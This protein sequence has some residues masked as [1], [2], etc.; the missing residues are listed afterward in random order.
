ML[1]S[2]IN[3]Y[4]NLLDLNEEALRIF[5]DFSS[6]S[7]S[8]IYSVSNGKPEYS[9]I[10]N[11]GAGFF[12]SIS[13]SGLFNRDS[14]TY[15]EVQNSNSGL[16]SDNWTMVFSQKTNK[17][18]GEN[19]GSVLFSSLEGDAIKSGFLIGINDAN[20]IYFESFSNL[21]PQIRTSRN[22]IG[23]KNL[24]SVNLSP[25]T[26]SFNYFNFNNKLVESESY[27]VNSNFILES[28]NWFLGRALNYYGNEPSGFNGY[29]DGF[30]YFN[31]S[32]SKSNLQRLFSGFYSHPFEIPAVTGAGPTGLVTG[33]ENVLTGILSVTGFELIPE[34]FI[35]SG[36]PVEVFVNNALTGEITQTGAIIEFL[37]NLPQYCENKP[38]QE[39]FKWRFIDNSYIGITGYQSVFSGVIFPNVTSGFNYSSGALSG[40]VSGYITI[41]VINTGITT[42]ELTGA[43]SGVSI[44]SGKIFEYG[45]DSVTF[46]G[47]RGE[48]NDLQEIILFPN[49]HGLTD[50]NLVASFDNA[51]QEFKLNQAFSTTGSTNIYLNGVFQLQSGYTESG[52]I[53]NPEIFISGDYFLS[54]LLVL[55]NQFFDK[56]DYIVFDKNQNPE[57]TIELN[58]D[59]NTV[60]GFDSN[61]KQIFLNGQK[62]YSGIHYSASGDNFIPQGFVT[63]IEGRIFSMDEYTGQVSVTGNYDYYSGKFPRNTSI[64]YLNG[65]RQDS[66]AYI[67]HTSIDLITGLKVTQ[68]GLANLFNL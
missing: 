58:F 17:N 50:F 39:I 26:V 40:L 38:D 44:D 10:V 59:G 37:Q 25:N 45:M 42:I 24:F 27:S 35:N 21:G 3:Y 6:S 62:I 18:F 49:Q 51:E 56:N 52:S 36:Q 2:G 64:Y 60:N 14:G 53:Y 34:L 15:I 1:R 11:N 5:Y 32:L 29:L 9:G 57:K 20:K 65:I 8:V 23:E 28:D 47:N 19:I 61:Q 33:Y 55:T 54:G 48:G 67:E 46:L 22:I 12:G 41:P 43:Q 16:H 63:G 66:R 31:Q 30:L 13:G 4:L 68:T 7:D